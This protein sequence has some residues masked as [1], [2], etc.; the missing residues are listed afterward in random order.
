MIYYNGWEKI[1]VGSIFQYNNAFYWIIYD[2]K[3]RPNN[4]YFI[5]YWPIDA[6]LD[7]ESSGNEMIIS[8]DED[9]KLTDRF[10]LVW[11][12]PKDIDIIPNKNRISFEP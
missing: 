10:D 12:E 1:T 8:F 4:S 11:I 9:S 7:Y 6:P 2:I 3:V 5:M